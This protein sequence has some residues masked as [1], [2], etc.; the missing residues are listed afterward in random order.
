MNARI[1][2][3]T[4]ASRGIGAAIARA[5]GREGYRVGVNYL[6]RE[7]AASA[8]VGDIRRAGGEAVALQADVAK[9]DQRSP[10]RGLGFGSEVF[11]HV[12]HRHGCITHEATRLA[13]RLETLTACWP[14]EAP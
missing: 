12:R 7:D 14:R 6:R 4:G 5:A 13:S 2:L 8:V 11:E 3:V 9:P 1:M 10:G